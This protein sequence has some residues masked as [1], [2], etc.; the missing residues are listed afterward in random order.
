MLALA[1]AVRECS[2]TDPPADRE[3]YLLT[4]RR[5]GNI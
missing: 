5:I 2:C 4:L 1:T 3:V